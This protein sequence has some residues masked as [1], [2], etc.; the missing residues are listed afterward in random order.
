[1]IKKAFKNLFTRFYVSLSLHLSQHFSSKN[2][3]FN[4]RQQ[5][6]QFLSCAKHFTTIMQAAL[7]LRKIGLCTALQ[8]PKSVSNLQTNLG[9]SQNSLLAAAAAVVACVAE[10]SPRSPPFSS[11]VF[12]NRRVFSHSLLPLIMQC[13]NSFLHKT[14]LSFVFVFLNYV[15]LIDK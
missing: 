12:V 7:G 9:H 15:F 10:L 8:L 2:F 6:K 11:H 5:R 4:V 1:M 3:T 14:N 13:V